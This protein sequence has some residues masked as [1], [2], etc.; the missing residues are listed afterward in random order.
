MGSNSALLL[1]L[2]SLGK[3]LPLSGTVSSATTWESKRPIGC[4][5]KPA[6]S[7]LVAGGASFSHCLPRARPCLPV[8]AGIAKAC[9]Q[10]LQKTLRFGGRVELPSSMELR[11]MLVSVGWGLEEREIGAPLRDPVGTQRS[12]AFPPTPVQSPLAWGLPWPGT[13]AG[14]DPRTWPLSSPPLSLSQAGRSSKRQLFLLPGGLERHLKI[15]TCTVREGMFLAG[16]CWRGGDTPASGV[17]SQ[18]C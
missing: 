11:A 15:K 3:S 8:S 10:N 16:R 17:G 13:I 6:G 7:W 4:G 1:Q 18:G 12:R 9:E 5:E 2:L 14:P